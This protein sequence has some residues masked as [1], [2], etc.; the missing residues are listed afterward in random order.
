MWF[1]EREDCP[2]HL[3]EAEAQKQKADDAAAEK[4]G[5]LVSRVES[6]SPKGKTGRAGRQCE[7]TKDPCGPERGRSVARV[8]EGTGG[9]R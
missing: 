9:V 6:R 1:S 3:H 7:T 2:A 5:S 8:K 4:A